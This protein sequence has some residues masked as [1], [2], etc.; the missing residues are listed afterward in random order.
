MASYRY[1]MLDEVDGLE[2]LEGIIVRS[3]DEE[4][5]KQLL[6]ELRKAIP[7]QL[8]EIGEMDKL[9]S[10][11]RYR[12]HLRELENREASVVWWLAKQLCLQGW[13][14]MGGGRF[15]FEDGRS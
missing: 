14:P 12:W 13:G 11:E 3:T 5:V 4:V 6:A 10:G 7:F 15:R 9:P 2:G 8:D 1:L